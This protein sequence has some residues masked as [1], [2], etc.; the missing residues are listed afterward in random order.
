MDYELL[1]GKFGLRQDL[2]P[3]G[4]GYFGILPMQ[5]G[6]GNVATEMS[7]TYDYGN[8][9]VLVP[10]MNPSLTKTEINHLLKGYEPTKQMIDKTYQFGLQ[11]LQEGRSPFADNK[12]KY[13]FMR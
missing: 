6:S 3:K 10:L 8:G 1:G 7:M 12:D 9:D 13:G 5:D 4:E 11:R 2:T